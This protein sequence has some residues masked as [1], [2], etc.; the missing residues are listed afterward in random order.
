M[1]D[2]K[3]INRL[4]TEITK[5]YEITDKNDTSSIRRALILIIKSKSFKKYIDEITMPAKQT[6]EECMLLSQ[7]FYKKV[8][9]VDKL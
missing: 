9:F 6:V 7:A 3:L 4:T 2:N 1:C 8:S 5:E